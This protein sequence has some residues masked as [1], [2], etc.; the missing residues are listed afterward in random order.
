MPMN[1]E[2]IRQDE[3]ELAR[4]LAAAYLSHVLGLKSID[5]VLKSYVLPNSPLSE[6]WIELARHAYM[7]HH[8]FGLPTPTRRKQ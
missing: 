8:K 7:I 2:E 4:R 1:A 6:D 5:R 3:E